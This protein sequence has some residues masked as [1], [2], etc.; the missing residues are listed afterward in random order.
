VLDQSEALKVPRDPKKMSL[1]L[2]I[3]RK[4]GQWG[5]PTWSNWVMWGNWTKERWTLGGSAVLRLLGTLGNIYTQ[6]SS[7][8]LFLSTLSSSNCTSSIPFSLPLIWQ[9][10]ESN[11]AAPIWFD[12][13]RWWIRS[14]KFSI[15]FEKTPIFKKNFQS[16][17][18]NS[19]DFFLLI[20][21]K[22][23][24]VTIYTYILG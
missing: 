9:R 8:P 20:N 12:V 3:E 2:S 21:S 18:Q 13:W 14:Q 23:V 6:G 4:Q 17:K 15:S 22:N 1:A 10:Y 11:P 24:N 16:S 19:D 5:I 7:P